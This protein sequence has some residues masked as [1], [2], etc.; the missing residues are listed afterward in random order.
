MKNKYHHDEEYLEYL[1]SL[2]KEFY[3]EI[4][5][6]MVHEV[7]VCSNDGDYLYCN[8]AMCLYMGEPADKLVSYNSKNSGNWGTWQA[9]VYPPIFKDLLTKKTPLIYRQKSFYRQGFNIVYGI[10][11]FDDNNELKYSLYVSRND[12]EALDVDAKQLLEDNV[13]TYTKEHIQ[14]RRKIISNSH[15]FLKEIITLERIAKS[16]ISI[17]M[18]GESGVGKTF[19]AEHI[20]ECS[21]HAENKFMS[22]NCG[23]ITE[24]LLESELFGYAPGAFTG[25]SKSGKK[26]IFELANGGTVFLDEIG[27]MPLSLQVK[28]LHVI[29]HKQF[30]PV[31]GSKPINVDFRIISATNKNIDELIKKQQ[32]R[33]DLYWR[34]NA[35]TTTIPPLRERIEDVIPI[36]LS[37]IKSLNEKYDEKKM[38]H[39]LTIVSLMN[40]NFPGNIRELKN[41]IERMYVLTRGSIITEN[42]LPSNIQLPTLSDKESSNSFDEI[43][44]RAEKFMITNSYER[45]KNSSETARE[46]KITQSKAYRLIKKY[47]SK[48]LEDNETSNEEQ[49][50]LDL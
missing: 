25:A 22:I 45:T 19:I 44:E 50:L 42:Q 47:C 1:Y 15:T 5:E 6:N 16:E 35:Y 4:L 12:E 26:G 32:F 11:L 37:F 48:L 2:P 8:P 27:D 30:V 41:I 43:L 14:R 33:D 21:Q 17:F 31:G 28:L 18:Q 7:C 46:L 23:A 9:K 38:L 20:H 24:S 40:Y 10:P 13:P 29:E 3:M 49:N 34:L 39:P 36:S